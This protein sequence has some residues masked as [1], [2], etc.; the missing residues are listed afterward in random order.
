M[1]SGIFIMNLHFHYWGLL[2][3]VPGRSNTVLVETYFSFGSATISLILLLLLPRIFEKLS[4]TLR[5]VTF[6]FFWLRLV[7]IHC[8]FVAGSRQ[9]LIIS[10]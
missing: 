6:S 9:L 10:H 8:S 1:G 4:R 5:L 7:H 2:V 3:V